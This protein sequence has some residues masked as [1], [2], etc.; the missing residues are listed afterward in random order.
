MLI[1][2]PETFGGTNFSI[3][4]GELDPPLHKF[5]ANNT[6]LLNLTRDANSNPSYHNGS[7]IAA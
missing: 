5:V 3:E 7:W 4:L 2:G 6:K 1:S